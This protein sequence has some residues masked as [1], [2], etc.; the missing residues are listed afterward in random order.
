[1]TRYVTIFEDIPFIM[2]YPKP[3][4]V[5]WS[6]V[7]SGGEPVEVCERAKDNI[8]EEPTLGSWTPSGTDECA[9]P[10]HAY[11]LPVVPITVVASEG[12]DDEE[13]ELDRKARRGE[14]RAGV[15]GGGRRSCERLYTGRPRGGGEAPYLYATEHW[16]TTC[17][18]F[19]SNF[20]SS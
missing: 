11:L 12:I 3:M 19:A 6:N 13:A 2:P 14:G 7:E 5:R 17:M 4:T 18:L 9:L 8:A 16:S 10:E 20:G 15:H 1:M